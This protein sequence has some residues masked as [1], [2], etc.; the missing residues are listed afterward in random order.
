MAN[1]LYS[2]RREH[3]LAMPSVCSIALCALSTASL[4]ETAISGQVRDING[5]PVKQALVTLSQPPGIDGAGFTTVFT[6]AEGRFAF[7]KRIQDQVRGD[8]AVEAKAL[9][10]RMVFPQHGPTKL[11]PPTPGIEAVELVLVLQPQRNQADSAPASAWLKAIPD[12]EPD[13]ALVVRE[14]VACHQIAHPEMRNFVR[15][16]DD[17]IV[18][19][20]Q[21]AR[22]RSWQ[23]LLIYMYGTSHE[24]FGDALGI[25]YRYDHLDAGETRH[26]EPVSAL[27]SKYLPD[28]LDYVEY[29]Y[30]APLAVT[31]KTQIREYPVPNLAGQKFNALGTREAVLAGKPL[32]LWV[33][34]VASDHIFKIDPETGRQTT[35]AVPF[36][37]ITAPHSIYGGYDGSLWLTYLFQQLHGRVNPKT[38]T[39]SVVQR[40]TTANDYYIS[41]DFATDW[42]RNVNTDTRGRIWFGDVASNSLGSTDLKT[43]E[44]KLYPVPEKRLD[45]D[46]DGSRGGVH[47]DDLY[48]YGCVITSDRKHIWYTQLN[49]RFGEFNIEALKYQT[50]VEVPPASG[51]RRLAITEKDILYVPLFGSGQIVEYDARAHKQL[52]VYDLPDRASA[53]YAV[54]WDPGRQVLW[55]ATSNADAIYRFNPKDHSFG[56]IPLPRQR[57]YLRM[58]Q[59]EPDTGFLVTSYALLP[60]RAPGPRMA[61]IID[62]GDDYARKGNAQATSDAVA[63]AA[64]EPTVQLR[65]PSQPTRK[66]TGTEL[67]EL[68]RKNQCVSCHSVT[69]PRIG[70]PFNVVAI[71]YSQQPRAVSV[72]VLAAKILNGGAGNWGSFPMIARERLLSPDEARALA[73]AILDL[74][75]TP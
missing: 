18:S 3:A 44:T 30:G 58:L 51:P 43:G 38:D 50:A 7:A 29:A 41:H 57:A 1:R 74:Q 13:K 11:P 20:P 55:V 46:T 31:S 75:V 24:F 4:A 53:P 6:D 72:E 28:R 32:S 16:M 47:L 34:D 68:S 17:G 35:L 73:A 23:Q 2:A 39:L 49:G 56:V 9:G 54:T 63:E 21:E 42:R 70:P 36:A 27:L 33:V 22:Q 48:V 12:S 8:V 71:R 67:E 26:L 69:E 61:L 25:P 14:C 59:V 15:S 64:K 66:V 10:Y 5:N 37:G 45:R 40:K 19:R 62:P 52:A 65:Q 60:A